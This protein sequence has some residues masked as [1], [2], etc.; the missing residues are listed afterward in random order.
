MCAIAAR[1]GTSEPVFVDDPEPRAPGEGEV[2]CRTLQLGVCGT[3]REILESAAPWAPKDL[4]YLI[5]GHECLAR[6]EEMI[7]ADPASPRHVVTR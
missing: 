7:R 4:D 2:L 6:V 5:L 1:S 3:D